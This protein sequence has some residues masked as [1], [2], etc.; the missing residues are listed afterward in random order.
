MENLVISLNAVL[1]LLLSM[2]VGYFV[3][4]RKW[5]DDAFVTKC[6]AF[7][8]KVFMGFLLFSNLYTADLSSFSA[9][10]MILFAVVA[11]TLVFVI[12][13][14][15]IRRFFL[16]GGTRAVLTQAI[17][18]GNYV[19]FGIP[20]A[21]SIYG[22]GNVGE[23]ALL[24][25]V[26]VPLFNVFAV[27]V[28]EYYSPDKKG[29]KSLF[30]GIATNP[31]IVGVLAALVVL[32][33]N[34]PIPTAVEKAITD[35]S[36]VSTPLS[37]VLLGASFHFRSLKSNLRPLLFGIGGKIFLFPLLILPVAILLGFRG[38]DLL[39]LVIMFAAPTAVTSYT[40][41]SA[42]GYDG[43]LAGQLVVFSSILA[44]LTIFL[45]IF[46]LKSFSLI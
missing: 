36:R 33:L 13:F 2:G 42:Y 26:C 5:V 39:C 31:A 38:L 44:T 1:P 8:F 32:L 46:A 45:W 34:I 37:L 35:L 27:V 16:D 14:F 18:R 24:A 28:M 17:F 30:R 19:I 15:G 41:A 12:S 43:E 11:E 9:V 29:V 7:A 21:T 10:K 23:A 20:I 3:R 22:E 25:A 4:L 40:M 6:N